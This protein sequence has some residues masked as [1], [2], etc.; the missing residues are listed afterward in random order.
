MKYYQGKFKPKN[1]HKYVGDIRNIN[2]RSGWECRVMLHLDNNS[3]ILEWSSEEIIIPYRSPLD[4]KI[5]RYY[6]DFKIKTINKCIILIEVKPHKQT[7]EPKIQKRMT[8]G[9]ITEVKTCGV[10]QAKWK[11]AQEFCEYRGW[12]FSIMTEKDLNIKW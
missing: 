2:Y 11:A 12:A 10:N 3:D 5:H 1:P 9:Y 4:G 8:K 7:Q 6:P